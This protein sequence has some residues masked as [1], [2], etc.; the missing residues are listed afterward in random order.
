MFYK[1]E[2][3]WNTVDEIKKNN[4]FEFSEG[5]KKFLDLGKTEREFISQAVKL[6]ETKGYRD[7]EKIEK[8]K[9]GD[10]IYYVNRGKNLVLAIIGKQIITNGINYVVSHVDSPRLDLKQNPLYEDLELSYMK[11]HYYGGIKKYH[12]ATLPLAMHGI[13]VCEDGRKVEIVIGE[14]DEDPV[15]TIPDLLPHLWGKSQA[16]RKAGEILTGEELQIIVGSIPT[17]I[18][19]KNIKNLVK[20]TV[21]KELNSRY[22]II[23]EDFISAEL[24][25]VPAGKSRDVG[26]DRSLIGAYGQDDRICGYTSMKAIFDL[27]EIPEKTV[28]CFLADK[29]ETGSNGSTGLQSQYLEYFTS[30]IIL[31]CFGEYNETFLRKALWN[32]KSLS[33]DVNAAIDPIF[34]NVHEIQNAAQLNYGIVVTKYTGSRGKSGTN[35]AD[36]E[37]VAEIRN[38]LN[39]AEIKWQT[40]MLGKIDEGGGGTVASF[41]AQKGIRTIDAGP[42]LLSMHAPFELASKFDIFETYKTYLSFYK[43]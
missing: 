3:G 8:L 25:L 23:E 32:S 26:L 2:N 10:K 1:K 21:L 5:Y 20:Y 38:M 39:K 30:D 43:L 27:E 7:A 13:V 19:D 28:V 9:T 4:I 42:A 14:K 36:A 37:Y 29:E 16:E 18:E 33:S 34:R 6:A 31:K 35:D 24:Q 40:G 41:L 22:G 15:F 12:W 17:I 11:T